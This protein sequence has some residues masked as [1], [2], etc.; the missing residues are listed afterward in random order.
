[1]LVSG[2]VPNLQSLSPVGWGEVR[3]PNFIIK[4]FIL[5]IPILLRQRRFPGKDVAGVFCL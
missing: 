1:M 2:K 4:A 5:L 3:T